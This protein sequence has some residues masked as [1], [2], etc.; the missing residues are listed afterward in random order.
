MP[1]ESSSFTVYVGNNCR[2]INERTTHGEFKTYEEAVAACKRIVDQW[3]L[4]KYRAGMNADE[5]DE[6]YGFDGDNPCVDPEPDGEHFSALEYAKSRCEEVTGIPY[7]SPVDVDATLRW[8]AQ[9]PK[10]AVR[11][12]LDLSPTQFRALLADFYVDEESIAPDTQDAAEAAGCT[13]REGRHLPGRR[14]A[15][16][17]AE[18]VRNGR[19]RSDGSNIRWWKSPEKPSVSG[20]FRYLPEF[21]VP[22]AGIEPATSSLGN[23]LMGMPKSSKC[24]EFSGILSP[25]T[26][27][28]SIIILSRLFALKRGIGSVKTEYTVLHLE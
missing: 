23:R 4:S 13:F 14:S 16:S 5:L 20:S 11:E 3:L 24:P 18:R 28:A 7:V 15:E 9:S 1:D 26:A 12:S 6:A 19:K 10:K 17:I 8:L 2:S 25:L 21:Q 27:F 22:A